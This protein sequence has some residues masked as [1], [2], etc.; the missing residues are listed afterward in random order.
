MRASRVCPPPRANTADNAFGFCPTY[1][2][3]PYNAFLAA[4]AA[5]MVPSSR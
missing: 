2:A 1:L 3:A 5:E 4:S